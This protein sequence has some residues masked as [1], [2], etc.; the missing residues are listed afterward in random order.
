MQ[1]PDKE[2]SFRNITKYVQFL[3]P[4]IFPGTQTNKTTEYNSFNHLQ[5][6]YPFFFYLAP[7]LLLK[8][9]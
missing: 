8:V 9:M 1:G 2:G 6:D 4:G 3:N 5:N 7:F